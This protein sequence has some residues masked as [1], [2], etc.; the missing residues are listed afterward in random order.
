MR[1]AALNQAQYNLMAKVFV[2]ALRTESGNQQTLNRIN[3][4]TKVKDARD[5]L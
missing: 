3:K 5:S 2:F 4:N 1:F